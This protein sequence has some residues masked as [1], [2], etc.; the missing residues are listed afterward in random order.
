MF[1]YHFFKSHVSYI[2]NK[3]KNKEII[4]NEKKNWDFSGKDYLLNIIA[5]EL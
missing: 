4:F 3:S 5:E 2:D 1:I